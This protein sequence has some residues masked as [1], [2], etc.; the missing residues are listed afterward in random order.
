[1]LQRELMAE[2]RRLGRLVLER[3]LLARSARGDSMAPSAAVTMMLLLT[4]KI[5]DLGAEIAAIDAALTRRAGT[6]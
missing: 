5:L 1:M 4:Y 3:D 2:R 6:D